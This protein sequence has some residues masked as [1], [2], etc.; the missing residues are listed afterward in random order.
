MLSRR[1]LLLVPLAL[2]SAA[3]PALPGHRCADSQACGA[4]GQCE[5]VG[6]CSFPAPACPSGRAYGD[7]AAGELGGTCTPADAAAPSRCGAGTTLLDDTFGDGTPGP[8]FRA[9]GNNANTAVETGGQLVITL[10]SAV[11]EYAGFESEARFDLRGGS[12][13]LEVA[14]VATLNRTFTYLAL[15][16]PADHKTRLFHGK[17]TTAR[18]SVEIDGSNVATR[19]YVAGER[20]WRIRESGGQVIWDVSADRLAWAEVNRA[21]SPIDLSAVSVEP[22]AYAENGGGELRVERVTVCGP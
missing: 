19:G 18:M 15:T 7:E 21:A 4:L 14:Q 22:W 6:V 8:A 2:A 17:V 20:Y 11:G 1:S 12:V 5:P 10:G 9:F 13:E 16:D 3:C